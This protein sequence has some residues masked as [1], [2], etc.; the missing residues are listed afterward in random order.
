M[1]RWCQRVGG[2]VGGCGRVCMIERDGL[3]DEQACSTVV[4]WCVREE[5]T[6]GWGVLE[7]V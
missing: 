4:G 5:V 7:C 2:R 3:G 6:W 1:C